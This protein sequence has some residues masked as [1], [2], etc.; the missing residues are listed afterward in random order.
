MEERKK[1]GHVEATS[2]VPL[3]SSAHAQIDAMDGGRR[4][5]RDAVGVAQ[6]HPGVSRLVKQT[7]ALRGVNGP[8]RQGLA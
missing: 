4:A 2:C 7:W 8:R 5:G 6:W 1:F 3:G